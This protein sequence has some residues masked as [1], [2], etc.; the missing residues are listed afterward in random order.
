[1]RFVRQSVRVISVVCLTG[2][3]LVF[4]ARVDV[5]DVRMW[6]S[7]LTCVHSKVAPCIARYLYHVWRPRSF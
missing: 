2:V 1:L 5:S 4:D 6:I 7:Q 3:T